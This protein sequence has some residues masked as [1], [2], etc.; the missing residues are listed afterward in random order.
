MLS[1]ESPDGVNQEIE[2]GWRKCDGD[3]DRR[4]ES[5]DIFLNERCETCNEKGIDTRNLVVEHVFHAFRGMKYEDGWW[6]GS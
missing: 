3:C 4:M 1:P 5:R 2:G 6:K